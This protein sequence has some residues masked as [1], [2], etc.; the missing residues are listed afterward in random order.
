[1]SRILRFGLSLFLLFFFKEAKAYV[2]C[3]T[4]V[5]TNS[6]GLLYD[7]GGP[8]ADYGNNEV[9]NFSINPA[10]NKAIN[11]TFQ[12]FNTEPG[13][14]FLYIYDG[15][16]ASA[17]L[18]LY[19]SGSSVPSPVIAYSGSVYI[20]FTS[21]AANTR[22]G[23]EITWTTDLLTSK[24]IAR[25][26]LSDTFPPLF[27]NIHFIDSSVNYISY[28]Q[29]DFGDKS[30]S[31]LINPVHFYQSS[32]L[33]YVKLVV[34]NCLGKD[35]MIRSLNV[36]DT[37][38]IVTSPIMFNITTNACDDS[39]TTNLKIRNSGKGSLFYDIYGENFELPV[40]L[41]A[42]TYGVDYNNE[43]RNTLIAINSYF[44]NYHLTEIYTFN[45]FVLDS[46][47]R[48]KDVFLI[49]KQETSALSVF[50]S[51]SAILKNFVARG[52]TVIF[53]GSLVGM[54]GCMFNTELFSGSYISNV[55]GNPVKVM[56]K[57][58]PIVAGVDSVF[59]GIANTFAV[60]ISN[61][62][63]YSLVN[64]L[65]STDVV[66]G[67]D[68]G[69]GHVIYIGFDYSNYDTN[70]SR[71]IA[72]AVKY[73]TF[74][75]LPDWM[76]IAVIKDTLTVNDSDI[77]W[78]KISAKKQQVKTYI[79]S[80]KIASNDPVNRIITIPF[81]YH[82]MGSAQMIIKDSFFEFDTLIRH[83]S[84]MDTLLIYNTGCDTL[85]INK[86]D[87]SS[88]DFHSSTTNLY[89][90]PF[91]TG[92]ITIT[93]RP[94]G[95][96]NFTDTIFIQHNL[97]NQN[98]YL[99]GYGIFPP[100]LAFKPDTIT[101]SLLC[102]DS[103][104]LS[105]NL[106]NKGPVDLHYNILSENYSPPV[107]LLTLTYGVDYFVEYMNTL[108][109]INTFFTNYD[110]TEVN[111]TSA[112]TLDSFLKDKE[113]LLIADQETSNPAVFSTFDTVFGKFVSKGGI[114]IFCG[115][116]MLH[117]D[118]MFN[119][120]LFTGF[121]A[122]SFLSNLYLFDVLNTSHPITKNLP[123][124][125]GSA[126]AVYYSFITDND[127]V[128][129]IGFNNMYDVACSRIIGN[130][131]A[132]YIGY[133][134][135][136]YNT[137]T[138]R[139]I[140]NA[141]Q[142]ASKNALPDWIRLSSY[143]DT[144][145]KGDSSVINI[146]FN[147]KH[148][149]AGRYRADI[150]I[151]TNDPFHLIDT[152]PVFLQVNCSPIADFMSDKIVVNP[153][154][155]IHFSDKSLNIPTT[156][157]WYFPYSNSPVSNLQHP[158]ITYSLN[159]YYDIT[160][161]VENAF[162]KDSITRKIYIQVVNTVSM[163][164]SL[165][166]ALTSGVLFDSGGPLN[167]YPDQQYCTLLIEPTCAKSITLSFDSIDLELNYDYI[168]VYNGSSK[169]GNLLL[170]ATGNSIPPPV[171]ANSGKMFIVFESDQLINDKGFRAKWSASMPIGNPPVSG[172]I[173]SD[174]NPPVKTMIHFIDITTENP[175][176][177]YWNFGD[178]DTS[179]L[180][181]PS[182]IYRKPGIWK[183]SLTTIN[184][185]GSHKA[186]KYIKVQDYPQFSIFPATFKINNVCGDTINVSLNMVNAGNGSLSYEIDTGYSGREIEL[187]GFTYGVKYDGEYKKTLE[188]ISQNFPNYHLSEINTIDPTVLQ[189]A[190]R[191]KD[192]LLIAEQATG[193]P[194]FFTNFAVVLYDFVFQGGTVIFC[195][196]FD[197]KANCMF[198]T[199]LFHGNYF[200]YVYQ[201]T[202]TLKVVNNQH[203]VT[204]HLKDTLGAV[205]ITY[206]CNITDMD[207]TRLITCKN[208]DV[209]TVR[210]IGKGKVIYTGFNYYEF[211]DKISKIIAYA[212]RW[213]STT[214][215]PSWLK[216]P[217]PQGI[218]K[219]S[220][221]I[222]L[223]FDKKGLINGTYRAV[224]AIYTNDSIQNKKYI[225]VEFIISKHYPPVNLGND[226]SICPGD[227]ML[228]NAGKN[229]LNYNWNDSL[230][231]SQSIYASVPG[232]YYVN[233]A[234]SN[235]C[236]SSDTLILSNYSLAH[237]QTLTT[238]DTFCI[239]D[240]PELLMGDPFGGVF[241]GTGVQNDFFI[242]SLAGAGLHLIKYVYSDTHHCTSFI[243][244][245]FF[246]DPL[247]LV[248][249]GKDTTIFTYDSIRLD[250]G[251]GFTSYNWNN[252]MLFSQIMTLYGQYLYKG[253]NLFFVHVID[254]IGCYNSDSI[255]IVVKDSASG[256]FS[257]KPSPI[258]KIYPNPTKGW[259]QIEITNPTFNE[260]EIY[261]TDPLG[262]EIFR[263]DYRKKLV[264][265]KIDLSGRAD[266]I[267]YLRYN[268]GDLQINRKIFLYQ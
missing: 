62:D 139:L 229:Y 98:I 26:L 192:I 240:K 56:N 254:T 201:N 206:L 103:T 65:G 233:V 5:S 18:I 171:T 2:M 91:D 236:I 119:T 87:L 132:V 84:K 147:A 235:N 153:G 43:Y 250:A 58:H 28:R 11:L 164:H 69:Y 130:G 121:Y 231:F 32:G 181:H 38:T 190:L 212:V 208:K 105:F 50:S 175:F 265:E 1:M 86:I 4:S 76:K 207:A 51:F 71:I 53:C 230:L 204:A 33:F 187:L 226:S 173:V 9:C 122:G 59:T 198:N 116:D 228:I 82:L 193:L 52:G 247:P 264:K 124:S 200:D 232:K 40:E 179:I 142:L 67:R 168:Y 128:Q 149:L 19:V 255:V 63:A 73:G 112:I 155:S 222:P 174:T 213:G 113:V 75:S 109:A 55:F 80:M 261:I 156:W 78:V 172:F 145:T 140:S 46:M 203:P 23:F 94:T 218:I 36:Q 123:G 30:V 42:L 196:S 217:Y 24:P 137:N 188:A 225:P 72:N 117:M 8:L 169:S 127:K 185:F 210:Q 15:T 263:K 101:L 95:A 146:R 97:G 199:G 57:T 111:T 74:N 268:S 125:I 13:R 22:S 180:Q 157:T 131:Q 234:D 154:D 104:N 150:V 93:F 14:D 152:L 68:T 45:P 219:D 37:P 134:Y 126:N 144:L 161:V 160:L 177:W 148:M 66:V 143:S 267:Y 167:N 260:S 34:S 114:V 237:L 163:C 102:G 262:K 41:L 44:K 10:C 31:S 107:K 89:I 60:Q 248:D 258:V 12:S 252:G 21:D 191:N 138:A 202:D 3:S 158:V 220:A 81:S 256:L 205:V 90:P 184:C 99:H 129:L 245:S 47:L 251:K 241:S 106:Y 79:G 215:L 186:T 178:G 29:W 6:T 20:V 100:E 110:L 141:V 253:Y 120:G 7:S 195:G 159:G 211:N 118:C 221:S 64:Y 85:K 170:T 176:S 70:A 227:S 151:N 244:D 243:E 166:T 83:M 54:T 214:P 39:V 266:G 135:F 165:T 249:L 35:S 257:T 27:G 162:G 96:G 209:V 92:W 239:Y 197:T 238:K 115:S 182:H 61:P 48:G 224:I 25:F 242:P 133:D 77:I 136:S 108:S 194:V 49:A 17:P 216:T 246:I 189:Q 259:I 88:P 183:V 223:I 16:N